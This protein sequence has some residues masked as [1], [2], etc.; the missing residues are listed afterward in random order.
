MKI[1]LFCGGSGSEQLQKGIWKLFGDVVQLSLIINGY[2]DG[3]S[4]GIV[5]KCFHDA[6]LGPSDL[7]KNHLLQHKLRY[8]ESLLY[9][10]L[11]K[12]SVGSYENVMHELN[13][14]RERLTQSKYMFMKQCV[15]GFFEYTKTTERMTD[16][17][18]GNIIYS[19]CFYFNGI[20]NAKLLL[21]EL[22]DI[23]NCVHFQCNFPYKLKATTEHGSLLSTEQEIS[24]FNNRNDKI[25]DVA[26]FDLNDNET[27]R[28]TIE[29]NI[30]EIVNT[31]DIIIIS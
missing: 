13:S 10:F 16:F 12:R 8:G 1:V 31:S 4:S 6:I 14:I 5:R 30:H 7:R 27:Q 21:C 18:F 26:L 29:K 17:N 9:T 11:N 19:Y 3:K 15:D 20:D 24:T 25:K 23:P 28:V 2:D 22:L